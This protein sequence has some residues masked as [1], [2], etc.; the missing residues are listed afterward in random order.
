MVIT[1]STDYQTS[2]HNISKLSWKSGLYFSFE[3]S[4]SKI[5]VTGS[6][7]RSKNQGMHQRLAH[8]FL[9]KRKLSM[10]V[11]TKVVALVSS[12]SMSGQPSLNSIPM[13]NYGQNTKTMSKLQ[14]CYSN[15][16]FDYMKATFLSI[17]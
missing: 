11:Y 5:L 14:R 8:N 10:G 17:L 2:K 13:R 7:I 12:F 16:F 15:R 6:K 4:L 3:L 9:L 1:Q